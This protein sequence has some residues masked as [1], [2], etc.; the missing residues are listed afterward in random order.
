MTKIKIQDSLV[1]TVNS[2]KAKFNILDIS[3]G[4]EVKK[5]WVAV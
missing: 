3:G 5:Y 2:K 1:I 4:R